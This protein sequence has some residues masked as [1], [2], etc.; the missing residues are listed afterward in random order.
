MPGF[1]GPKTDDARRPGAPAC[2]LPLRKSPAFLRAGANNA[3]L[4]GSQA[5]NVSLRR[6]SSIESGGPAQHRAPRSRGPLH[7]EEPRARARGYSFSV[8]K[9]SSS[10]HDHLFDLDKSGRHLDRALRDL[11]LII[12]D[13]HSSLVD[14]ALSHD[15]GRL[16][17]GLWLKQ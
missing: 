1:V 7:N 14:G 16:L 2:G 6:R 5:W 11:V 15:D 10:V 17:R 8:V 3:R 12:L 4:D 13:I 9:C